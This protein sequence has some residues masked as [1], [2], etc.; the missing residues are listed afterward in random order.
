MGRADDAPNYYK[1]VSSAA[2]G[3]YEGGYELRPALLPIVLMITGLSHK[4]R[5]PFVEISCVLSLIFS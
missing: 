4:D 5:Q 3:A 2:R 1:W